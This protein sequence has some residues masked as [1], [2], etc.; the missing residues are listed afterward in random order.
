ML[1]HINALKAYAS[2][3]NNCLQSCLENWTVS[4]SVFKPQMLLV[5]S[6]KNQSSLNVDKIITKY[7][8]HGN[9]D[10]LTNCLFQPDFSF[11]EEVLHQ[12]VR[13]CLKA[14][15]PLITALSQNI[16]Q[17]SANSGLCSDLWIMQNWRILQNMWSGDI[18]FISGCN[19]NL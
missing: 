5:N 12:S 10:P 15:A 16:R 11:P 3:S 2:L 19:K 17:Y 1:I 6:C 14:C 4:Y 13:I 9:S 7:A 8:N 18:Q